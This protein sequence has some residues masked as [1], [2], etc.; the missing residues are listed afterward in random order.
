MLWGYRGY[1]I[2]WLAMT[3]IAKALSR[4]FIPTTRAPDDDNLVKIAVF[5][6]AGLLISLLLVSHGLDLGSDFLWF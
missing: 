6:G 1:N 5:C 4:I 3:A 2:E